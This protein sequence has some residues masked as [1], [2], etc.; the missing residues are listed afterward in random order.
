MTRPVKRRAG[1]LDAYFRITERGSSVR[2][3]VVAGLTTFMTMA[4]ILFVNPSILTALPDSEG[5]RLSPEAVLTSTALAAGIAS[6]AMGLYARYP[7]ALAAGLGLNGI[8]AFQLLGQA[9]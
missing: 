2:T 8:V 1:G 9:S 3:E 7:F 4:Y 5:V 6:V